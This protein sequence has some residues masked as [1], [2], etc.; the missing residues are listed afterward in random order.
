[1]CNILVI[2]V[3]AHLFYLS[4]ICFLSCIITTSTSYIFHLTFFY[5]FVLFNRFDFSCY[6]SSKYVN[7]F[8]RTTLWTASVLNNLDSV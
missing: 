1:M 6:L 8:R 4:D 7:I 2:N 5:F 3:S